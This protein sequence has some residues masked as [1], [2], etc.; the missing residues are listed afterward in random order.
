VVAIR[1]ERLS[2]KTELAQ[3]KEDKEKLAL[4]SFLKNRNLPG[5]SEAAELIAGV[6][7][8]NQ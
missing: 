3:N 1:I 7:G 6:R 8:K 4:G 2:G 5:D